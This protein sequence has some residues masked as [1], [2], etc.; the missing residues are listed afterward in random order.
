MHSQSTKQHKSIKQSPCMMF[1]L[2]Y[3]FKI[4]P[5]LNKPIRIELMCSQRSLKENWLMIHSY[6]KLNHQLETLTIGRPSV[7]S[8]KYWQ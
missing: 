1:V 2:T 6:L 3:Y 8:F 4:T 7:K 5:R